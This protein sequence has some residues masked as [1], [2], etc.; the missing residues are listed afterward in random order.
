MVCLAFARVWGMVAGTVR[1]EVG[2]REGLFRTV[3]LL[4]WRMTG[5]VVDFGGCLCLELRGGCKGLFWGFKVGEVPGRR[6]GSG[7][8]GTAR[9]RLVCC[10]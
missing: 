3:L 10:G 4:V 8:P 2:G 1:D 7:R 6:V 5:V 9:N